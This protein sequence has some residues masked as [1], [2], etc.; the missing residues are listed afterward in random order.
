MVCIHVE[1]MT[2]S[3]LPCVSLGCTVLYTK[4]G[5][6][7]IIPASNRPQRTVYS[8]TYTSNNQHQNHQ[9]TLVIPCEIE[10]NRNPFF[11]GI[12][13]SDMFQIQTFS[14]FLG[15]NEEKFRKEKRQGIA[16]QSRAG[17]GRAGQGRAGHSIAYPFY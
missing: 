15:G 16:K 3:C 6:I 11:K 17:Q 7:C 1:E 4:Y 12:K 10:Q 14:I 9:N 13:H 2:R 5:N 8:P